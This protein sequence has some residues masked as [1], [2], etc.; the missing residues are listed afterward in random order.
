ME[1]QRGHRELVILP[2]REPKMCCS[3]LVTCTFYLTTK[4]R[5]FVFSAGVLSS[6]L[7]TQRDKNESDSDQPGK[8]RYDY[9]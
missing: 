3:Q 2:G 7:E 8:D 9:E 5:A 1:K 4:V 6:P